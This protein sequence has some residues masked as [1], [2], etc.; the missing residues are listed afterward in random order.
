[1]QRNAESLIHDI[2]FRINPSVKVGNLSIAH[3]QIVEIAK[4]LSEKVDVLILDE[5]SAVLGPHEI[6]KL[7]DTLNRLKKEGV[8]IIYISH[9]LDEIFQIAD[10]VTVL[11]DG[12]SGESL[13]VAETN[14]DAIIKRML[15]RSLNTMYP[16]G[17]SKIGK[18]I[19]SLPNFYKISDKLGF[20]REKRARENTRD[21]IKKLSIKTPGEKAKVGTLSGATQQKVSLAKWIYRSSRVMMIDEPTRGVDVGAKVEIYQLI[22]ELSNRGMAVIVV[23]SE[24]DELMGICDRILVMRNGQIQGELERKNFSEEDILRLS[25]GP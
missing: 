4:A 20:I 11:K 19:I 23:S 12:R 3:Q 25:I 15:G 7:F 10:R 24:T 13:R 8:S 17:D 16:V 2:G 1:M 14:R 9:H 21:L 5:P 18:E 6:K 22:N